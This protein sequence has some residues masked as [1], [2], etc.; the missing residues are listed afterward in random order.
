MHHILYGFIH[1]TL[2]QTHKTSSGETWYINANRL[3]L[4]ELYL[5][6]ESNEK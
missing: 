5:T 4:K 1:S 6:V 3:N 2:K